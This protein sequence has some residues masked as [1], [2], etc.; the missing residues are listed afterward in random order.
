MCIAEFLCVV[1]LFVC[2]YLDKLATTSDIEQ[3]S[4]SPSWISIPY[5][6]NRGMLHDGDYPHLSTPIK[7][8]TPG[9]QRVILG[10]NCFPHSIGEATMR[11]PEHSDAFNRTVKLYQ[12]MAAAGVPITAAAAGRSIEDSSSMSVGGKYG[13]GHSTTPPL[14][15]VGA[16]ASVAGTHKSDID[17]KPPS[18]GIRAKDLLNNPA[19]ARIIVAAA[20][21]KKAAM[22]SK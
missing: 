13:L 6:C 2:I 4:K 20:K 15:R 5:K 8:I 3:D 1:D 7:Y 21:R 22:I 9:H 12:A 10:F 18:T 16:A 14:S 17:V 11:A 19:L